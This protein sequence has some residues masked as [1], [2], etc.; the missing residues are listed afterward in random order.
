MMK[1]AI[2]G[3]FRILEILV[4]FYFMSMTTSPLIV[5]IL[6]LYFFLSL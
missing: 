5:G 6:L 4:T 3:I 1:A 2:M